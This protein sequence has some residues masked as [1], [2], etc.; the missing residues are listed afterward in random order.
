MFGAVWH[1]V[2]GIVCIHV[3]Q[4]IVSASTVAEKPPGRLK[5]LK[6]DLSKQVPHQHTSLP[7]AST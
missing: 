4:V 3:R 5:S 6:A 7:K 1:I 2:W